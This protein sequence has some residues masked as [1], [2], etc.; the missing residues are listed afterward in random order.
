MLEVRQ[1]R[2][3]EARTL[4]EVAQIAIGR[5]KVMNLEPAQRSDLQ[6]AS[7]LLDQ[8]HEALPR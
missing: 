5:V 2:L 3:D 1:A 8:V 7:R 4:V 6:A